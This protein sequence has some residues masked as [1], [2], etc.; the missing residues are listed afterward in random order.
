[1]QLGHSAPARPLLSADIPAAA[2]RSRRQVGSRPTLEWSEQERESWQLVPV[3][4]GGGWGGLSPGG[5]PWPSRRT[6]SS[7]RVSPHSHG[8]PG[9]VWP[10][11]GVTPV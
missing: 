1:M 3:E 4:A 7:G 5:S 8:L 9:P 10:V 2:P 11:W 6:P